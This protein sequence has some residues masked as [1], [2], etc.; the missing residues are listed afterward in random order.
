MNKNEIQVCEFANVS[1]RA[2]ALDCNIPSDLAILPR[3]FETATSKSELLHEISTPTV[4]ILWR[5]ANLIETKLESDSESFPQIS[6][7]AEDWIGP[8][9]FLSYMALQGN[10]YLV[11][12]SIGVIANYISD[13]FR[14]ISSPE[15]KIKLDIVCQK[16]DG[17]YKRVKYKGNVEG[18][19]ELPKIVRKVADV[20]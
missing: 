1:Q 13:L 9:I 6:E 7:H 12:L 19:K 15:Q 8:I 3:N 20:E 17:S 2:Q 5:Q 4:R 14:G 18:L 16:K 11:N 10:P